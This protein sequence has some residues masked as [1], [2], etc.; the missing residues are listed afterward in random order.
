MG[1]PKNIDTWL[2]HTTQFVRLDLDIAVLNN[3]EVS[4]EHTISLMKE[5]QSEN[6]V[7]E[8]KSLDTKETFNLLIENE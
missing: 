7:C 6:I 2:V 5:Y 8:S 1:F 4:I 3:S